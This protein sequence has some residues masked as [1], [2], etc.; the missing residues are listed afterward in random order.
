[1]VFGPLGF[2]GAVVLAGAAL[3]GAGAVV[4]D[5]AACGAAAPED[6]ADAC[7]DGRSGAAP[8]PTPE[9]RPP[10]TGVGAACVAAEGPVAAGGKCSGML[11]AHCGKAGGCAP[12]AISGMARWA[13]GAPCGNAAG[14]GTG[15]NAPFPVVPPYTGASDGGAEDATGAAASSGGEVY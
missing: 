1:M 12:P 5:G 15:V 10:I 4:A 8:A 3:A 6:G 13:C 2:A 14:G 7:A 9:V 11:V